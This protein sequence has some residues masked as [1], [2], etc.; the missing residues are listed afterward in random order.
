[1]TRRSP[2]WRYL[3]A[4]LMRF[5]NSS[6]IESSLEMM[7]GSGSRMICVVALLDGAIKEFESPFRERCCSQRDEKVRANFR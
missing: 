5:W 6:T 1:M 4:L 7:T 3:I 2:A